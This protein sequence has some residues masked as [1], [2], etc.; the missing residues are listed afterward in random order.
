MMIVEQV[1][2][3]RCTRRIEPSTSIHTMSIQIVVDGKTVTDLRYIEIDDWCIN[4]ITK[5]VDQYGAAYSKKRAKLT[6]GDAVE[7]TA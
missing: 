3:D 2:C 1:L 4:A 6:G 5:M 7:E